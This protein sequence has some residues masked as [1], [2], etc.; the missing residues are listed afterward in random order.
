MW[1]THRSITERFQKCRGIFARRSIPEDGTNSNMPA[2]QESDV[3]E[4]VSASLP[5][6][7]EV[8]RYR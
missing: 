1:N 3:V 6:V 8:L 5:I 2:E 7:A 4:S